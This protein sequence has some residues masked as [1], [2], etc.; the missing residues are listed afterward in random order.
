MGA[1]TLTTDFGTKD[2][3]VGA[4]KGVILSIAP[5]VQIVDITHEIPPQDIVEAAFV[6]RNAWPYF[7]EGTVHVAVI[8]PGVGGRRRPLALRTRDHFFVGPDNGLFHL[9][10]RDVSV[11]QT[12]EISNPSFVGPRVSDTFHGRDIFAP[13]AAHLS[14]GVE[15]IELGPEVEPLCAE[16]DGLRIEPRRIIG[17]VIHVD[18]FGNLVTNISRS[19]FEDF[20][21]GG[22]FEVRVGSTTRSELSRSYDAVKPGETLLI[23]GSADFLEI[24]VNRRSATQVLKVGKGEAVYLTK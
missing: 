13:A 5:G 7:P 24:S 1:I 3:F 6:L 20:L 22:L 21:A 23:F 16:S 19:C 2:Y 11:E 17:Q 14:Q 8:D 10:L 4:M 12:V 18:R 15:L 9:V